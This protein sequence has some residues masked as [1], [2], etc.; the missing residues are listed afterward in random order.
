MELFKIFLRLGLSSFGGP[1]AHIAIFRDEFVTRRS[2]LSDDEYAKLVALCHMLPG[3]SSSQVGFALGLQRA[4]WQ[5]ALLAFS[6][7]TL[8]SA[9]LMG[10]AGAGIMAFGLDAG[11]LA[12]IQIALVWIVGQALLGMYRSLCTERSTQIVAAACLA[13]GLIFSHPLMMILA[14]AVAFGWPQDPERVFQ[15]GAWPQRIQRLAIV[16]CACMGLALIAPA[17]GYWAIWGDMFVAGTLAVGG[18]H[19]VLPWLQSSTQVALAEGE[20]L[21]GYSLA[22]LMPG[23]LFSVGAFV[24]AAGDYG[25]GLLG[26][27]VLGLLALFAPGFLILCIALPVWSG[28]SGLPGMS[29]VAAAVVGLLAAVWLNPIAIGALSGF[30][31]LL[32]LI[33]VL[34]L[35][36]YKP[37]PIWSLLLIAGLYGY[38]VL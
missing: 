30:M 15:W 2:W 9:V 8:P 35:Q 6:G 18:G 34:A 26:G 19:G 28:A 7:F 29:R 13:W 12:G 25:V 24:G 21:A 3:P 38:V 36:K 5:G 23:P 16:F 22:Q 27:S 32:G 14:L 37:Q 4:G 1:M 17:T 10:L 11:V 33:G 31:S 20:L